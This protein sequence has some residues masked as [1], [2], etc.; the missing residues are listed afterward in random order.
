MYLIIVYDIKVERINDVR[1]YLKTYLNWVQNSV[2]EGEVTKAEL[3]RIKNK[4]K[5][6]INE[7][8]DSVLIY[9]VRLRKYIE[10]ELMGIEKGEIS[11]II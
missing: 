7:K 9:E 11:V 4:I 3:R 1:K 10:R 2:F 6:M 5:E 8:E